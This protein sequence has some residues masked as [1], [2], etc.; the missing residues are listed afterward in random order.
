M[1]RGIAEYI[2]S[3]K[4][5]A[6]LRR[7]AP[8]HPRIT[9]SH[10][11]KLAIAEI[12]LR[13]TPPSNGERISFHRPPHFVKEITN[14]I[15][16]KHLSGGKDL[17]LNCRTL[18]RIFFRRRFGRHSHVTPL[19]TSLTHQA[20]YIQ[21]R[22]NEGHH[23]EFVAQ[24]RKKNATT[25]PIGPDYATISNVTT[26]DQ[27]GTQR[28][29]Y[30][31]K[32]LHIR[33]H[34]SINQTDIHTN[35]VL[36]D[37]IGISHKTLSAKSTGVRGVSR[38]GDITVA[39]SNAKHFINIESRLTRL[40]HFGGLDTLERN[41]ADFILANGITLDRS[42]L[43]GKIDKNVHT[44][45]RFIRIGFG[46]IQRESYN[47]NWSLGGSTMPGVNVKAFL[48]MPI[49]LRQQL[50]VLFEE[51]T[52]FTRVWHKDSFSDPRRNKHCAGYLNSLL[53][54]PRSTSLF[55]FV[56][57][58]ISLNTILTKHCDEKDCHRPGYNESCVYSYYIEIEGY[59]YKVS[60]V[61]TTRTTVGC[62]FDKAKL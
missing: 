49:S 46:R 29:Q 56:D 52:S 2:L 35:D 8:H 13:I 30:V 33:P 60:I 17:K 32:N 51:S 12:A 14:R 20:I 11:A 47:Q 50:M 61:M 59:R 45:R 6:A 42:R 21:K 5:A 24:K 16:T 15:N 28:L 48:Q 25:C 18:W 22:H 38:D 7:D 19:S 27:S 53:G 44:V 34:G 4:A 31:A 39:F 58:I 26:I 1:A 55:E 10:A 3:D 62:A 40:G 54:F 43:Q 37:F 36:Y 41:L 23:H 57:V 9:R